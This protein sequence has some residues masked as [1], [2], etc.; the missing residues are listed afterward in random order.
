MSWDGRVIER[1]APAEVD[2]MLHDGAAAHRPYRPHRPYGEVRVLLSATGHEA[3]YER[4]PGKW[5]LQAILEHLRATH[6]V[7]RVGFAGGPQL[8][9][10]MA[11][12]GLLD[13]LHLTWQ[14]RILG[15]KSA[16]AITGLEEEFL[17]R[18]IALDLLKL[19]RQGDNCQATYRVHPAHP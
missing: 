7:R 5:T 6:G 14:P 3:A 12:A 15:G 17:P 9:R 10:E 16:P 2:A 19:K 13:E 11:A 8:F 1:L 18:G 4:G